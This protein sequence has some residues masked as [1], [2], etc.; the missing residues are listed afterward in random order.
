MPDIANRSLN[1]AFVVNGGSGW[2]AGLHYFQN[3]FAAIRAAARE[4]VNL[5]VL[6]GEETSDEDL[7]SL[8]KFNI[9]ILRVPEAMIESPKPQKQSFLDRLLKRNAIGPPR[10]VLNLSKEERLGQYLCSRNIHC[11]FGI[12]EFGANFPV[13]LI[14]WIYDFQHKELPQ[15]FSAPEIESRD[16]GFGRM[17][18][19]A[20]MVVLSSNHAA[21]IARIFYPEY[22][23]KLRVMQ[24]VAQ[25]PEAAFSV[26]LNDLTKR[27]SLPE[28]FVFL[29]NQ[30]WK[31]KNHGIVI[32]ALAIAV[33]SDPEITLVCSGAKVD[34]RDETYF[35]SL[36]ARIESKNLTDRIRI[37]GMIPETDVFALM[38]QSLFLLQPSLYEGWSTV[39][40]QSKSLGKEIILSNLD[41][42]L[43]QDPPGATFFDPSDA[44]QLASILV[45][46]YRTSKP[47]PDR[48]REE[49]AAA[50]HAERSRHYGERFLEI[51]QEAAGRLTYASSIN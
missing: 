43:E 51:A 24:F 29:P 40:E 11:I 14:S 5:F 9:E 26:D 12:G 46:K 36:E 3:L 38:R 44:N 13:P 35:P 37:L 23:H 22:K 27:Y 47:G 2:I 31:H 1:L 10:A 48:A 21:S 6:P 33:K 49:K 32:D 34:Y 28:K 4:E 18:R 25:I 19:Y 15:M 42:H 16:Y 39:V 7:S 45:S 41:V 8:R 50:A 20:K 17:M 30:F